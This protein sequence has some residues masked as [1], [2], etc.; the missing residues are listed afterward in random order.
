MCRQLPEYSNF[1]KITS[2][3]MKTCTL[4]MKCYQITCSIDKMLFKFKK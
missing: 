3:A 2:S 4:V 1:F